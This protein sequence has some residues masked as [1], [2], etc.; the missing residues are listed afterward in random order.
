MFHT[1]PLNYVLIIREVMLQ[2]S[3]SFRYQ[4]INIV[5]FCSNWLAMSNSCYNPFIYGLLNVSIIRMFKGEPESVDQQINSTLVFDGFCVTLS[6]FTNL[7][8]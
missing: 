6:P 8:F 2:S 4:H 7:Y 5:W 1:C 3:N